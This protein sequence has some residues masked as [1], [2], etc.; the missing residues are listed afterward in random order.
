LTKG[1]GDDD[2]DADVMM[3]MLM[4]QKAPMVKFPIKAQVPEF[5]GSVANCL[6]YDEPLR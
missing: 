3:L 1:I 4:L 6:V 2:A 5:G